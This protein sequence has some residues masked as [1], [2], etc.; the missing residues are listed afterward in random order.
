MST[1]KV[2]T[3]IIK[4]TYL[5]PLEESIISLESGKVLE[6]NGLSHKK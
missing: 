5:H 6:R 4:E 2:L 3:I 1:P